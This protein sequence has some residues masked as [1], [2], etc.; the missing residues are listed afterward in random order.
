MAAG[1]VEDAVL[2]EVVV[3]AVHAEVE[4]KVDDADG[5]LEHVPT[6]SGGSVRI[7]NLAIFG[8]PVSPPAWR[9]LV[10]PFALRLGVSVHSAANISPPFQAFIVC[11]HPHL[12]FV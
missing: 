9:F 5:G 4:G 6:H 8:G 7:D 10:A 3:V 11:I 2:G 1:V 12:P